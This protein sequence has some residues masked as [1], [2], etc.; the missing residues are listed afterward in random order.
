MGERVCVSLAMITKLS[1]APVP[2]LI[3]PFLSFLTLEAV[4]DYLH[5]MDL[6]RGHVQAL[7]YL[8]SHPGLATFN[9]GTGR[10]SSVLEILRAF[11]AASKR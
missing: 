9:L 1:M 3:P 2:L 11:E 10:G 7:D 5:V 8:S 4:R 6:A